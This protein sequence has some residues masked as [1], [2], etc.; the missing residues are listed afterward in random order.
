MYMY[1]TGFFKILSTKS[2][3]EAPQRGDEQKNHVVWKQASRHT[4]HLHL[5][6]LHIATCFNYL[7]LMKGKL[8]KCWLKVHRVTERKVMLEL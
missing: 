4:V 7:E 3:H 8:Y 5:D 2:A 1:T 6:T